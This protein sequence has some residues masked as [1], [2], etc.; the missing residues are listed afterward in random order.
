MGQLTRFTLS[1]KSEGMDVLKMELI[2]HCKE[3]LLLSNLVLEPEEPVVLGK[4]G[5]L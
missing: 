5:N 4:Y 1:R 3:D 2:H